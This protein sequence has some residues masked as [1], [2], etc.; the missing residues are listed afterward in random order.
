MSLGEI[1]FFCL[2]FFLILHRETLTPHDYEEDNDSPDDA[3]DSHC[4]QGNEL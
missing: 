2:F 1:L 4:G 3:G